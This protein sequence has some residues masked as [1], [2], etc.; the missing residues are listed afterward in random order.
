MGKRIEHKVPVSIAKSIFLSD[1]CL[2]AGTH[3]GLHMQLL[4]NLPNRKEN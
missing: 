1:K 4:Q 3:A 2:A